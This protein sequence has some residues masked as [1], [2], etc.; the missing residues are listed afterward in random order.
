MGYQ[1][2][3]PFRRPVDATLLKHALQRSL[4]ASEHPSPSPPR[5]DKWVILREI[6]VARRQL[7]VSDRNL[8]V[9]QALLSF[10]KGAE[11]SPDDRN[12]LVVHPSNTTLSERL[13]GM[14]ASTLRRHLG[15]LVEAGLILRRDSP[16]GKRYVRR[17]RDGERSVFG[18]DLSPLLHRAAEIATLAEDV[19]AEE[20][21][22]SRLRQTVSLM[23][24]DL[25]GL[26]AYGRIAQPDCRHW[27]EFDDLATLTGRYLRRSHDDSGLDLAKT[28]L[29][30]ALTTLRTLLEPAETSAS[31][32]QNERH[33]QNS[34][35]DLSEFEIAHHDHEASCITTD[36]AETI[37]REKEAPLSE[38]KDQQKY[39]VMPLQ[40]V[41][42]A[43]RE[44]NDYSTNAIR[45][46]HEL[47]AAIEKVRPMM[48]ISVSAWREAVRTMGVETACIVV[49]AILERFG[50]IRNPGGYLRALTLKAA[51][52]T[53]SCGPMIMSRL[54][55]TP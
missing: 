14:P 18:L 3:T 45:H 30:D 32:T 41:L 28:R 7:G 47:H 20:D 8:V 39:P 29:E 16:N 36:L 42:A 26:V 10:T 53:F 24:R 48:G 17:R 40:V 43:C 11:L 52:G 21:H 2:I 23:R 5:V 1:T 22:R 13:N 27:D 51:N 55:A 54:Q 34:H 49:A 50:E 35:K 9:L 46:W 37:Y 33:H 12:G 38:G 15:C 19:R 4:P 6:A 31:D 44:V 25:A